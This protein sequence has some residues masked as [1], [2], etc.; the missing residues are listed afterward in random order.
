M[1]IG[2]HIG[3]CIVLGVAPSG[4]ADSYILL[5][6]QEYRR[7]VQ[8]VTGRVYVR[9]LPSPT[10]WHNGTYSPTLEDGVRHWINRSCIAKDEDGVKWMTRLIQNTEKALTPPPHEPGTLG[11]FLHERRIPGVP[12][13]HE[14]G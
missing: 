8:Y 5:L 14:E 7:H 12:C 4:D 3:G 9:Q 10:E 1:N 6:R 13:G 11:E 2:S